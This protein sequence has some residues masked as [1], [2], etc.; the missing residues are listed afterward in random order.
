MVRFKTSHPLIFIKDPLT[1]RGS[2]GDN[3]PA[4]LSRDKWPSFSDWKKIEILAGSSPLHL[5]RG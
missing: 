3:S 1:V 5:V 4:L 2:P